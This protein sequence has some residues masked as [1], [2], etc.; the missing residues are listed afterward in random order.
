VR[1]LDLLTACETLCVE[2][3]LLLLPCAAIDAVFDTDLVP[4]LAQGT[5]SLAALLAG[6]V[7]KRVWF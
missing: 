7:I 4:L 1:D 5:L 6:F 2:A 3:A